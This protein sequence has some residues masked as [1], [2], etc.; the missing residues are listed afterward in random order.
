MIVQVI[1]ETIAAIKLASAEKWDQLWTNAT[2]RRRYPFQALIVGLMDS[3]KKLDPVT[4]SSCIFLEDETAETI[5]ESILA[6]VSGISKVFASKIVARESTRG[7]ASLRA[8]TKIQACLLLPTTRRIF[9]LV[10]KK[11][12]GVDYMP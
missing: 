11:P 9:S 3:E 7:V 2:T 10:K 5:V 8:T 4:V 1:G 12:Y 6:E